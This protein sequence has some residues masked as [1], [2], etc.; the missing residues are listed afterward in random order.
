LVSTRVGAGV[1]LAGRAI[2]AGFEQLADVIA[3][4][5]IR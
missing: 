5:V 2:L 3:R 1:S 4:R